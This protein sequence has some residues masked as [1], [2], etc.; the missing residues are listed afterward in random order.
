MPTS[1]K[2]GEGGPWTREGTRT[3]TLGPGFYLN[4]PYCPCPLVWHV[5]LVAYPCNPHKSPQAAGTINHPHF[6][7]EKMEAPRRNSP[8]AQ[9]WA[10]RTECPHSQ[11]VQALL[12]PFPPHLPS[13]LPLMPGWPSL[14]RWN[15]SFPTGA[16]S[17]PHL[18][19]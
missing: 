15:F 16:A 3:Y 2:S 6:A 13:S 19:L 4:N 17:H 12:P 9:V 7:G 1:R 8:G 11:P 18:L 14:H 5:P 10:C